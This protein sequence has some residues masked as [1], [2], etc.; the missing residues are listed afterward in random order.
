MYHNQIQFNHVMTE[1]KINLAVLA[2]GN[3]TNAENIIRYFSDGHFNAT[4]AL[5]I[6]NNS[7]AK[8]LDRASNLGVPAIVMKKTEINC[9][10]RIS[11]VLDDYSIDFIV[12]AGFCLMVPEFL[13]KKYQGKIVN[14]HPALLPKY[15]GKGMYGHHVH[16]AVCANKEPETGITIH[17]VDEKYDNGTIFFQAKFDVLP[18]DTPETVESKIHVLEQKHFPKVIEQILKKIF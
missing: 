15:G 4:V 2:S 6:C 11:S 17:F 14:I 7:G 8:V 1:K 12:L 3:G 5:V 18:D 13:V 9:E 10:E 16:E